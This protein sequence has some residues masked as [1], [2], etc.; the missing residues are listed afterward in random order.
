M[1]GHWKP[2]NERERRWIDR[3]Q[4]GQ[5]D[6]YTCMALRYVKDLRDPGEAKSVA[7][8][9]DRGRSAGT[10]IGTPLQVTCAVL[11]A[12]QVVVPLLMILHQLRALPTFA[13]TAEVEFRLVGF[14]LY[15]YSIRNM[16]N[17][18]HD[19]CRA[20]YLET[21]FEF[22]LPWHNV[23]PALLGEVVNAFASFTLTVTLFTV[24]CTASKLQEL[25][26]NCV[27]IN[28]IGSVD[29]EFTSDEMKDVA[30]EN[31]HII[32]KRFH[33][34]S[35]GSVIANMADDP[36]RTCVEKSVQ[37]G[38][39]GLRVGGTLGCGMLFGLV[40]LFSHFTTLCTWVGYTC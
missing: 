39:E 10:V 11:I 4:K 36:L 31:Y 14:I 34:P 33:R 32:A 17:N 7:D 15:L 3:V 25:V 23:W 6:V 29:Q 24:F 5:L 16:Y 40:F 27:A 12:L 21:A 1:G 20:M 28:F 18:A 13:E 38:V 8:F 9:M 26:I 37:W 22:N 30:I 35:R 2:L 19:E